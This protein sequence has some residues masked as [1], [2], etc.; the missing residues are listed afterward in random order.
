MKWS[1]MTLSFHHSLP[2]PKRTIKKRERWTQMRVKEALKGYMYISPWLIGF[3]AFGLWPLLQTLYY[4]FTQF[5]LFNAPQWIGLQNYQQILTHD[6]IFMQA[7]Q[8]MLIYLVFSTIITTAG[9]FMLALLLNRRIPGNHLFRT[10]LYVPSLLIGVAMA[11]LFRAIFASGQYG[12]IN[13]LLSFFHLPA[14]NWLSDYDHPWV[15]L[16]ALILVNFW[17]TGGTM[18]VYLAG[19]KGI[20]DVYYEVARID[21]AGAWNIFWRITLP[22][23]SPAIIF[24]VIIAIIGHMQVFE[25][26]LVFAA[27]PG[28]INIGN[29]N[30]LGY[31]NS[32]VVF[33]TYIYHRA[34]VENDYGYASALSILVFL[35]TLVLALIVLKTVRLGRYSELDEV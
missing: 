1:N 12:M 26:P 17:F 25:M 2:R 27:P 13:E 16:I 31:H 7:C 21:G 11:K 9:G 19:L 22:L 5:N 18:L 3:L 10:I 29:S 34:F 35:L 15:A 24:T 28:G 23:I 6:P 4:S 20:P 32:L 33:L 8:N 14:V 30:P